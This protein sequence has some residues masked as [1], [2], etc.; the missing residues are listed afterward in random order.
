MPCHKRDKKMISLL[1]LFDDI[2]TTLDDIAVMTQTALQKTSVLMTD[3]LAVNAGVVTGTAADRELP[4]VK[5]I[6]IGSLWNKVISIT[7]VL[8]LLAIYEP[9]LTGVLLIGGLYLVFEGAHKLIEKIFPKK[10]ETEKPKIKK[11]EKERIKGAVRTDLVLSI[12]IIL[13]AKQS[14]SGSFFNQL[15]S[16]CLVGLAASVLIYGLVAVLVKVDDLG[17]YLVKK[18]YKNFGMILVKSMPYTMKGLGVLGTIAMFLVGG[19]IVMHVFHF[20]YL[21]PEHLQNL[22]VGLFVGLVIVYPVDLI[23]GKFSASNGH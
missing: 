12:E 23:L 7:G 20:S 19:G 6:F 3:D 18:E 14:I 13:I 8:I 2:A 17:I 10:I 22:V 4:I 15:L 16:L 11:T 1:S 9:L 5:A 21:L